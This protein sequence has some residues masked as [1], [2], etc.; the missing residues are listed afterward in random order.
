[1]TNA[2]SDC[3]LKLWTSQTHLVSILFSEG[4]GCELEVLLHEVLVREEVESSLLVRLD[5]VLA[6]MKREIKT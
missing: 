3:Y 2:L 4:D 5:G 6:R 1:M